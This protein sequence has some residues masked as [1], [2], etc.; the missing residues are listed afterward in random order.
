MALFSSGDILCSFSLPLQTDPSRKA[1]Y[2]RRR[3]TFPQNFTHREF[4]KSSSRKLRWLE[5]Q[6]KSR[7]Y[8]TPALLILLIAVVVPARSPR[9]TPGLSFAVDGSGSGV[10]QVHSESD[11][12]VEYLLRLMRCSVGHCFIPSSIY[13][14]VSRRVLLG[15]PPYRR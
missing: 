12:S 11:R 15:N 5:A 14:T 4:E 8:Q 2:A 3:F 1:V 9:R 6:R 13:Q 10:R 7:G